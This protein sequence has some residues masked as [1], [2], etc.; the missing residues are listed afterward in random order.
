MGAGRSRRAEAHAQQPSLDTP[1]LRVWENIM[2]LG[3]DTECLQHICVD[4]DEWGERPE[5]SDPSWSSYPIEE[6]N[7]VI[8]YRIQV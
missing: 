5:S 1:L 6:R 7:I 3:D 4:L 2:G 8:A